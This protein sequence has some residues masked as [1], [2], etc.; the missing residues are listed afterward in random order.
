MTK[1]GAPRSGAELRRRV[2]AEHSVDTAASLAIVD[3]AA[4]AL[5]QAL[6]AERVLSREGLT[7]AGSRGP[8]PHPCANIA[9]DARLRLL[10]ALRSLNLE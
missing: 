8:R 3:T 2:L 1:K 4:A 5:D 10:A 6:K 7:V 9:R